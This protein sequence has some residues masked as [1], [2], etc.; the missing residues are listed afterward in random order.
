MSLAILVSTCDAY[1]PVAGFTLTRL[2]ACWP[3]HPEVLVCGLS[4]ST[5]SC[6]KRLPLTADPRDWV[7]IMLDAARCLEDQGADW[8][9]LIL[10]DHPPFGPCNA[11]Y[12]N[13]RLPENAAALD[14]I[15]V[16]LLGWDQ[17]QPQEGVVLGPERLFWQRNSPSFHWKFSLHPGLWCV[18]PL[19]AMLESLRSS[20]PHV[21]SARQFEGALH[22]A[23]HRLDPRLLERTYR[24]RGDGFTALGRWF[25]SR[26]LRAL[27]RQLIRLARRGARLGGSRGVAS[28]D[29]ALLPYYRYANGPYPMFWSGIL[30]QGRL[31]EEALR[32]LAWTGRSALADDIRRSL[33]PV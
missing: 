13:R 2:D 15:Q 26:G 33:R 6:G 9:Y 17:Y 28:V 11:D 23:C 4:E 8:L 24:V 31:H 22:G 18:Q 3:G 20:S 29:T 10:D 21:R 32:F 5:V 25:E 19:R 30:R 7:G 16:N 14:A 1:A 27:T 12:L